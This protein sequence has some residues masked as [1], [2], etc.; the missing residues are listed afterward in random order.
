[1]CQRDAGDSSAHLS[2]CFFWI[3]HPCDRRA[4]GCVSF[5]GSDFI[6]EWEWQA[7]GESDKPVCIHSWNWLT[8]KFKERVQ[9]GMKSWKG[10][11]GRVSGSRRGWRLGPHSG[12]WNQLHL[13]QKLHRPGQWNQ[14]DR[15]WF[16]GDR[17]CDR[18]SFPVCSLVLHWHEQ[19]EESQ[20]TTSR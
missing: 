2:S 20:Q 12:N 15:D 9:V 1:M 11:G 7:P 13:L 19:N 5:M 4:E 16:R 6:R 10:S 18:S 14:S 8:A 3:I 17:S